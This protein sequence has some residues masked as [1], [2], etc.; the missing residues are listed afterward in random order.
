MIEKECGPG[1][2]DPDRGG[3]TLRHGVAASIYAD[4][5]EKICSTLSAFCRVDL[6]SAS[7]KP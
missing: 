4:M 5:C 1:L 7:A 6:P 2:L 3:K